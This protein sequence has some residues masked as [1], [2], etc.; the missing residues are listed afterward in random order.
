MTFLIWP[1]LLFLQNIRIVCT[2]TIPITSTCKIIVGLYF[3]KGDTDTEA[4]EV[5][6]FIRISSEIQKVRNELIER[7][8]LLNTPKIEF[9]G[10]LYDSSWEIYFIEYCKQHKINIIHNNKIFFTYTY[11][12]K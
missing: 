2:F 1:I 11:N 5:I 6:E 7:L 3:I 9:D 4:K 8:E 12:G 10:E